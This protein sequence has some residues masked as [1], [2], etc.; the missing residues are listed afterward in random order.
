LKGYQRPS[1][2]TKSLEEEEE[3]GGSSSCCIFPGSSSSYFP[4]VVE[5]AGKE[6]GTQTLRGASHSTTGQ[7]LPSSSPPV[8]EEKRFS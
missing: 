8:L 6:N 4:S 1:P 2:L 7:F 3:E 5:S